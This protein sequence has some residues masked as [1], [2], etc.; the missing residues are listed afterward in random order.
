MAIAHD[1]AHDAMNVGTGDFTISLWVRPDLLRDGGIVSLAP[2]DEEAGHRNRRSIRRFRTAGIWRWI[3][4]AVHIETAGAD[5]RSSGAVAATGAGV[6]R[7]NTW[8]HVAVVVKR[9]GINATRVYINGALAGKGDMG[10]ADLDN[11]KADLE[12]LGARR[13]ASNFAAKCMR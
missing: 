4:G 2:R 13:R 10:A 1:S 6:L 12:S 5:T 7:A 8:Q 9:G 3:T 11:P